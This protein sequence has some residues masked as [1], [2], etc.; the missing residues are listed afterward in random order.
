MPDVYKRQVLIQLFN[1]WGFFGGV[2]LILIL[3]ATTP[4]VLDKGYLYPLY[5]F[6]GSRMLRLFIRRSMHD[7][8]T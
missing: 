7:D 1:L 8:N 6:D 5:P 3:I 4:T 2:V